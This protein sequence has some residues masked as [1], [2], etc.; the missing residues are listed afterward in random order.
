MH[1][2][3]A[4]S[5]ELSVAST[6]QNTLSHNPNSSLHSSTRSVQQSDPA[7]SFIQ[8]EEV[9]ELDYLISTYSTPVRS[10]SVSLTA[11]WVKQFDVSPA[12]IAAFI[13]QEIDGTALLTLTGDD[14]QKELCIKA[15]GT[16]RRIL[17]AIE[18]LR[19]ARNS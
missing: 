8:E 10:W 11:D 17:V 12:S 2:M 6:R 3:A 16:R 9:E 19:T 15:L 14:L 4:P 1:G 18:S 13:E 5:A 7:S